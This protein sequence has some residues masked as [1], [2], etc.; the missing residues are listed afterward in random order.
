MREVED[1][2]SEAALSEDYRGLKQLISKEDK[3]ERDHSARSGHADLNA[4]L[5]ETRSQKYKPLST[6]VR[7]TR[8]TLMPD[9]MIMRDRSTHSFRG[10]PEVARSGDRTILRAEDL[11]K[12]RQ[13]S[14]LKDEVTEKERRITRLEV[15]RQSYL[16]E[17]EGLR[18]Q[19]DAA[20]TQGTLKANREVELVG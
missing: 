17:V 4:S 6:P 19:L 1:T 11:E 14:D 10:D 15:E 13:I 16:R 12:N 5:P 3:Y 20:K 2:P 18:V 7:E 8:N 9:H